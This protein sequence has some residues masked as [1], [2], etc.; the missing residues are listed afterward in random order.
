MPLYMFVLDRRDD[1]FLERYR[2]VKPGED[3]A[4]LRAAE[5]LTGV[6]PE[7]AADAFFEALVARFGPNDPVMAE[8][9]H[10]TDWEFVE[11]SYVSLFRD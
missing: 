5:D 3:A 1:R 9:V 6:V 8:M 11:S 7:A 2:V 4:A 10:S